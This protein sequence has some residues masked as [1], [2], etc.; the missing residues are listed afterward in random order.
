M[1]VKLKLS[2]KGLQDLGMPYSK[3]DINKD[4]NVYAVVEFKNFIK[5]D[6]YF[7]LIIH[8]DYASYLEL[9]PEK[10][11]I[12]VDDSVDKKWI[13]KDFN[14]KLILKEYYDVFGYDYVKIKT[15]HGFPALIENNFLLDVYN[16]PHDALKYLV[17]QNLLY[18]EDRYL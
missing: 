1:K 13:F 14:P 5:K 4:Y 3:A 18:E 12:I 10:K 15:Y 17:E 16:W 7:L 8:G 6:K 9:V 2:K 11:V